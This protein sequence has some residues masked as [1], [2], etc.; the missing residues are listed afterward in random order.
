MVEEQI[1]SSAVEP[2]AM[3][4]KVQEGKHLKKRNH[5]LLTFK[6]IMLFDLLSVYFSSSHSSVHS[7]NFPYNTF[8]N[9]PHMFTVIPLSSDTSFLFQL[10]LF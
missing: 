7:P 1:P 9:I 10:L 2:E 4:T 8:S 5:N 3:P 6:G